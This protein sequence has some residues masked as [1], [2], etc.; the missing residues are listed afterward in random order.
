MPTFDTIA[1][2]REHMQ[3]MM[4]ARISGLPY[5]FAS[6]PI[7][8]AWDAGGGTVTIDGE[9]YTWDT[10]LV[11]RELES[12]GAQVEPKRGVTVTGAL[13]VEFQVEGTQA[14]NTSD[15]WLNL[16]NNSLHR[17]DRNY[18][19]L[20][21]D[22]GVSDTTATVSTTTGWASSGYAYIGT[23]T[24]A[25]SGKT[26]TTLT[27]LTR[28]RFASFDTFHVGSVDTTTEVGHSGA[29]IS[30]GPM[31]IEGRIIEVW[32]ATG[33]IK[34]RIFTPYGS[35]IMST[36]DRQIY[37]GVIESVEMS[38]GLERARSTTQSLDSLLARQV[39]TR[40]ARATTVTGFGRAQV[41]GAYMLIDSASNRLNVRVE[42]Q[43][44]GWGVDFRGSNR[45]TLV[46][47]SNTAVADGVYHITEVT[48]FIAAT[49]Q[50][51]TGWSSTSTTVS[52]RQDES[53]KNTLSVRLN[54]NG[55]TIALE[56]TLD[57]DDDVLRELGFTQG[58]G[59]GPISSTTTVEFEADR[60]HPQFRLPVTGGVGRKIYYEGRTG[61]QFVVSPGYVDDVGN[62][63]TGY[64]MLD[65]K[66]V[67][68]ISAVSEAIAGRGT[69]TIGSRGAAGSALTEEIYI[70]TKLDNDESVEIK[71]VLHFPYVSSFRVALY[72]MLGIEGG[73]DNDATFDKGWR[74]AGIGVDA[75]LVDITS[76]T[77]LN[78]ETTQQRFRYHTIT[79]PTEFREW[80]SDEA[81]ACQCYI[82][83]DSSSTG[84]AIRLQRVEPPNE[85]DL[86]ASS[87]RALSHS[88]V[89]TLRGVQ[90]DASTQRLVN[91]VTAKT[92]YNAATGKFGM[93]QHFRNGT[94]I[95]TYGEQ[96]PIE[97]ELK[98][99]QET[100]WLSA[101]S[102][103]NRIVSGIWSAY[104]QP[105]VVVTFEVPTF[106]A[107]TWSIGDIVSVTHLG[108]PA[109]D[110]VGRGWTTV[111]GRI[112][113]IIKHYGPTS[114]SRATVTCL[115]K[116]N[117]G[118]RFGSW[119]PSAYLASKSSD[120]SWTATANRYTAAADGYDL[121]HFESG[122]EVLVYTPGTAT[123][124]SATVDTVGDTAI[125]FTGSGITLSAPVIIVALNYDNA[126]IT[127]T[128]KQH[129]F[130]ASWDPPAQLDVNGG[131]VE[132][133]Y[134]YK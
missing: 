46:D 112:Y 108:L 61:P 11:T 59:F 130:I 16:L 79:E 38:E 122:D 117:Q 69:L 77:N 118:R 132:A 92:R 39:L 93:V 56:L 64:V 28:G 23:E 25:Y 104:S 29:H 21:A 1:T 66:E 124:A 121:N 65:D 110:S 62:P 75:S 89:D 101:A 129:A 113:K 55:G 78:A 2:T 42:N 52:I 9:T 86:G 119:S 73:G 96:E 82:T 43:S 120:T 6:E 27:G 109:I 12:V 98:G 123:T 58:K 102:V 37:K 74:G 24:V 33:T 107:W 99:H 88:F 19:T 67:I 76:F 87:T 40:Q 103:V 34:N 47:T 22:L 18:S 90:W 100:F 72:L 127:A 94:S 71:Q 20:T 60:A 84:H 126:L 32:L 31:V 35:S 48:T 97:I 83:A 36:S 57:T 8:S 50:N 125:T 114:Q 51:A 41:L 81:L 91:V 115:V 106:A 80:F 70:E 131:G 68:G 45:L 5:I 49:L 13:N 15:V 85:D 105:Y 54:G 128:Q 44:G 14:D 17:S 111:L 63:I 116:R 133:G 134:Y 3:V 4:Y 7:P 10:S 26:S 53:F 30:D 95:G